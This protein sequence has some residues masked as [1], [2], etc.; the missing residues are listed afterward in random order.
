MFTVI[1]LHVRIGFILKTKLS[2][3]SVEQQG[4]FASAAESARENVKLEK[5]MTTSRRHLL[6][7]VAVDSSVDESDAEQWGKETFNDNVWIQ[8]K[9]IFTL[10]KH[11]C[12]VYVLHQKSTFLNLHCICCIYYFFKQSLIKHSLQPLHFHS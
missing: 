6:V 8:V 12:H 2:R 11:H 5:N 7:A 4:R 3:F 9:A 1:L 10:A